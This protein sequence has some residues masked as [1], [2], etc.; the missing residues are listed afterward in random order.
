MMEMDPSAA[1]AV[2]GKASTDSLARI[3]AVA[4]MDALNIIQFARRHSGDD[5]LCSENCVSQCDVGL[6]RW[7]VLDA[8]RYTAAAL[9][10]TR[11]LTENLASEIADRSKRIPSLS[12]LSVASSLV[13]S[14]E[15]INRLTYGLNS[16]DSMFGG[17]NRRIY[18]TKDALELHERLEAAT[19]IACTLAA[20]MDAD[21]AEIGGLR[22]QGNTSYTAEW[23][24]LKIIQQV[25]P[26]HRARY[27]E[28]FWTEL[29][30][31]AMANTS[32][33]FQI[34]YAVQQLSQVRQLRAA[35][36]ALD[37]SRFYRLRR[38]ACWILASDWRT[39]GFLGPLM[40]F[41]IVNVHLRQGWGSAFFTI[42]GVVAFY[43]GVEWLRKRWVVEFK[44]RGRSRERSSSE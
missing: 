17:G 15:T 14:L 28:E 43:A 29:R 20:S 9:A 36:Q 11:Q 3:I 6:Y 27:A 8:H 33:P 4:L 40:A 22:R 2:I 16:A 13:G 24:I 23:L 32:R 7:K 26:R 38:M 30:E 39:W 21:V 41:A 19:Q 10:I 34:L 44:R 1:N 42:P 37:Q 25:P 18:G 5:G 31:L 12:V 35:L